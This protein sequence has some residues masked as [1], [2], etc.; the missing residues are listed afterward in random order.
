MSA[1]LAASTE[2]QDVAPGRK[3]SVWVLIIF[4]AVL[5]TPHDSIVSVFAVLAALA[6][7]TWI[8]TCW[9]NSRFR[10][11]FEL[12]MIWLVAQLL[13]NLAHG[14]TIGGA[15]IGSWQPAVAI[16]SIGFFLW[17]YHQ[18]RT[19]L[20][21]I[22]VAMITQPIFFSLAQFEG[23]SNNPW[24]YIYGVPVTL[25]GAAL[26]ERY[27]PGR[28]LLIGL[29]FLAGSVFNFV[30][31]YRSLAAELFIAAVI[32][33]ARGASRKTRARALVAG[34]LAALL[35]V[36]L[37]MYAVS[38]GYTS[39]DYKRQHPTLT[40]PTSP[41]QYVMEGRPEIL[42]SSAVI[43]RYP[44]LGLGSHRT[45]TSQDVM[46]IMSTANSEHI[47]LS[48][49]E[50]FRL[51]GQGA[52]THSLLPN[53]WVSAGIFA[54]PFWLYVIYLMGSSLI[55][56]RRANAVLAIGTPMLVWDCFF[57]PWSGH[58]EMQLGVLVALALFVH[59][60]D[61]EADDGET[62]PT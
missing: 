53:A 10:K 18:A 49:E 1:Q 48:D 31:D 14:Y 54:V 21:V 8:V 40:A 51:F 34:I 33:V 9:K 17:A 12:A 62:S 36:P 58:Y 2:T 32:V 23:T 47:G 24:K 46:A 52:N 61:R 39:E 56:G 19:I 42:V 29:A 50:Q 26:L 27:V 44:L 13:S 60:R 43:S 25:V 15:I 37:L 35:A 5:V 59:E 4:T 16:V 20:P 6:I 22:I 7:P 11:L 55:V 41:K 3:N 45:L 38:H 57:S 30:V 28:R